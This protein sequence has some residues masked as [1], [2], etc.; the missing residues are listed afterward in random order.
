[1]FLLG[2]SRRWEK[3]IGGRGGHHCWLNLT[4][5]SLKDWKDLGQKLRLTLGGTKELLGHSIVIYL[6]VGVGAEE[7][8]TRQLLWV[9][10]RLMK[11]PPYQMLASTKLKNTQPAYKVPILPLLPTLL[12]LL[13]SCW[14]G[15][16]PANYS[17]GRNEPLVMGEDWNSK[18]MHS[19][20][21]WTFLNHTAFRRAT[22]MNVTGSKFWPLYAFLN[23]TII[24]A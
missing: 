12:I 20:W 15:P 14:C 4:S 9:S 2:I 19:L 8:A 24:Y 3:A 17:F 11:K 16:L 21:F 6:G 1:M 18:R 10:E 5:S 22:S 7:K 23:E 13:S